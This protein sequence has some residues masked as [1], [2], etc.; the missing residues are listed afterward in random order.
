MV[1]VD[2]HYILNFSGSGIYN[3]SFRHF[4][5]AKNMPHTLSYNF[6]IIILF[7][8][9]ILPFCILVLWK[10][11][12]KMYYWH[13]GAHMHANST[14]LLAQALLLEVLVNLVISGQ[15]WKC[16]ETGTCDPN[17]M[18][19]CDCIY[20]YNNI[21]MPTVYTNGVNSHFCCVVM[22]GGKQHRLKIMDNSETW[23]YS[24]SVLQSSPKFT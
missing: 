2:I 14:I 9:N 22:E 19:H 15:K 4:C 1:L 13:V 24:H 6:Y 8:F 7:P 16:S 12:I 3:Q 11:W 10:R 5:Y 17:C 23:K 21:K 20:A 18:T